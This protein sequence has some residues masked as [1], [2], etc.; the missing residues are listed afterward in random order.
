[1]PDEVS[2]LETKQ[3]LRSIEAAIEAARQNVVAGFAEIGNRLKEIQESKLYK[4]AGFS[5]FEDYCQSRWK[6]KRAQAYRLISAVATINKL[7]PIGDNLLPPVF[8]NHECTED[9]FAKVESEAVARELGQIKDVEEM[10]KVW[11]R[12]NE[13]ARRELR[14]VTAQD[15]TETF[16]ALLI[17]EAYRELVINPEFANLL[18]PAPEEKFAEMEESML[19]SGILV[20]L[21]VWDGV[22][23]DGHIRYAI[24]KKHNLPF[25]TSEQEFAD[26]NDA[27][28]FIFREHCLRQ[29]LTPDQIACV[30]VN[31]E[32]QLAKL[33]EE[34]PEARQ[35]EQDVLN[36]VVSRKLHRRHLTPSQVACV[37]VD[38]EPCF[39]KE[40]ER[41]APHPV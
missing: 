41:K 17:E 40:A 1:M 36:F 8:K 4:T 24:A 23:I 10:H 12:V 28:I 35:K 26:E 13:T 11:Q 15:V 21:V 29:N 6:M 2:S 33:A 7:S 25:A 3:K 27:K 9:C 20:P 38:A 18:P 34:E 37:A 22:L 39:A 30:A 31:I 32:S 16:V 19:R 5:S 14:S